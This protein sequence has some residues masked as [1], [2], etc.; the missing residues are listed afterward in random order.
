MPFLKSFA[1]GQSF[2]SIKKV[3]SALLIQLVPPVVTT[4][5]YNINNPDTQQE[6]RAGTVF[7]VGV[8]IE[9]GNVGIGKGIEKIKFPM[10]KAGSPPSTFR[11]QIYNAAGDLQDSTNTSSANGLTT[12]FADI[13]LTLAGGIH[14]IVAGDRIIIE[15]NN[16]DVSNKIL[17]SEDNSVGV[18]PVNTKHVTFDGSWVAITAQWSNGI[19]DSDPTE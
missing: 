16:G 10:K 13:E 9:S 12:S 17:A 7:R 6:I 19:F 2:S 15:Y 14:Q 8:Q 3:M 1:S 18:I 11:Y 5:I 4:T